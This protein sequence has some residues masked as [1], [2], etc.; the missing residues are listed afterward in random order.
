[1]R[2]LVVIAILLAGR[3]ARAEGAEGPL[4][5]AVGAGPTLMS[6][7]EDSSSRLSLSLHLD[8][9]V[10]IHRNFAPG[11]H[12]GAA[13]PTAASEYVF[14]GAGPGP[15]GYQEA[16]DYTPL[17]LGFAGTFMLP[18]TRVW[19]APWF[20]IIDIQTRGGAYYQRPRELGF[21]FDFGYDL[22]SSLEQHFV[23]FGGVAAG[24]GFSAL[25]LGVGYRYW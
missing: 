11:I 17:E 9:G 16:I 22:R 19:M 15:S 13:L 2:R 7:K 6:W 10:R 20:G 12:A 25:T 18:P 3:S 5:V 23:L 21:G 14:L 8:L 24:G 1:M 4:T